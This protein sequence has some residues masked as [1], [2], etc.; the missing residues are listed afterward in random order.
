MFKLSFSAFYGKH[1]HDYHKVVT[2]GDNTKS[3]SKIYV[4]TVGTTPTIKATIPKTSIDTFS[5]YNCGMIK[6][7]TII[8]KDHN[9]H[10][11][12][13]VIIIYL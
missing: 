8:L 11:I 4:Q 6:L 7:Y 12:C 10:L 9:H 5:I 1:R 13:S 2:R 3:K